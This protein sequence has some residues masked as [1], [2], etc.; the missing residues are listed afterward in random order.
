MCFSLV[1]Q[2]NLPYTV[3]NGFLVVNGT[4]VPLFLERNIDRLPVYHRLDFSWTI[5]NFRREKRACTGDWVFT[6]Y[7]FYGRD[8]TYNIFFPP[9]DANTPA[10]GIF[11]DSPFAAYRRSIFWGPVLS[12]AYKF[13]FKP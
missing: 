4:G 8:N 3:L 2:S 12:L 5:H 7:N 6:V 13:T 10:L 1:I 9:R 11:G